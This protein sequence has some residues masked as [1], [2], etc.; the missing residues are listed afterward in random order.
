MSEAH[1]TLHRVLWGV[2]ILLALA[3][4]G[5]GSL[6][7]TTPEPGLIEAGMAWVERFPVGSRYP[8]GLC[9]VLGAIGLILPAALGILPRL[10]PVAAGL[11]AVMM[12]VAMVDHVVAGELVAM[13][14]SVVLGSLS[15]FVAWGRWAAVPVPARD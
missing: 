12:A 8:I 5:G 15:A 4:L 2:Q 6:K 13:L 14:P 11:L 7:L 9:E 1:P 3:F 10:T